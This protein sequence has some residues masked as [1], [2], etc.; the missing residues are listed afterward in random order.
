MVALNPHYSWYFDWLALPCCLAPLRS[1]IYLSAA[2]LLL[3][4]NPWDERF[5]WAALLYVPAITLAVLDWRS[6]RSGRRAALALAFGR[7]P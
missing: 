6:L 3:D 2:G 1:V 4:L 5:F 7:S